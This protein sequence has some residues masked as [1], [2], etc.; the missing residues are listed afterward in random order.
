MLPHFHSGSRSE[1]LSSLYTDCNVC[2]RCRIIRVL[3]YVATLRRSHS[4]NQRWPIPLASYLTS[5]TRLTDDLV[6]GFA[7]TYRFLYHA[8]YNMVAPLS[9]CGHTN[10]NKFYAEHMLPQP[11]SSVIRLH[12]RQVRCRWNIALFARL[13]RVQRFPHEHY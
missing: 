12:A 10:L 1:A 13:R 2:H 11:F 4:L 6:V 3:L 8:R 5:Y 7:P 9:R